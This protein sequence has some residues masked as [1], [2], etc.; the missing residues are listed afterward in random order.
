MSLDSDVQE[1]LRA[2]NPVS[3]GRDVSMELPSRS[4]DRYV[5]NDARL[6]YGAWGNT[7][8]N[9]DLQTIYYLLS[10]LRFPLQRVD[11]Y[12]RTHLRRSLFGG[13]VIWR[14][15]TPHRPLERRRAELSRKE[16]K[17][18]RKILDATY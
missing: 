2:G 6:F 13:L 5:F 16:F 1:V 9:I 12:E 15:K 18:L 14:D 11:V 10:G 3:L 4:G 17:F 8:Y 7:R